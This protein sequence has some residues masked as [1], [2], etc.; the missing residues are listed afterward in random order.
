MIGIDS[1]LRLSFRAKRDGISFSARVANRTLGSNPNGLRDFRTVSCERCAGVQL[2]FKIK[3]H[4]AMSRGVKR[5]PDVWFT[6]VMLIIAAV[7]LIL[8]PISTKVIDYYFAAA[9]VAIVVILNVIGR[10]LPPDHFT[11]HATLHEGP[12]TLVATQE[13]FLTIVRA[14]TKYRFVLLASSLTLPTL[15]PPDCY[16]KAPQQCRP[17][18]D[19]DCEHPGPGTRLRSGTTFPPATLVFSAPAAKSVIEARSIEP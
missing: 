16:A 1:S 12:A 15:A 3:S 5:I 4:R 2:N 8:Q 14:S 11:R 7:F 19:H 18:S 17:V 6:V 13:V 9:V 10:R